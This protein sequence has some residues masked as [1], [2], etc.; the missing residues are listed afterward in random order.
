M[1]VEREESG[2][3]VN[4]KL[5]KK[6]GE[7]IIGFT[8]PRGEDQAKRLRAQA[9]GL[10]EMAEKLERMAEEMERKAQGGK[11]ARFIQRIFRRG[12]PQEAK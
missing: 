6:T 1:K 8:S 9:D 7:P 3:L 12:A 11:A 10:R 5:T 4:I 2:K